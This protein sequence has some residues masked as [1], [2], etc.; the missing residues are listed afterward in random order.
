[1]SAFVL[2]AGVKL[3]FE[4]CISAEQALQT[5]YDSGIVTGAHR[6]KKP[7]LFDD[8]GVQLA[9]LEQLGERTLI[10]RATVTV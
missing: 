3:H 5:L 7:R 1:M 2:W 10:L 8:K 6:K 9:R 4:P